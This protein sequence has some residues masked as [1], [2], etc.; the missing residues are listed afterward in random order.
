MAM[1]V[2][3]IEYCK[4]NVHYTVEGDAVK[5]KISDT[6][7]NLKKNKVRV[8][9][10]RPGKASDLAIRVHL[11]KHINE[12]VKE[13]LVAQ[14]YDDILFETKMKPI[15]YPQIMNSQLNGD[16]FLV[17]MLFLKKPEFE[18]KGYK[19]L[20]LPKPHMETTVE[21]MTQ[22]LLQ[23]L[24]EFHGDTMPYSETDFV[25]M[26]DQITMDV[27]VELDGKPVDSLAKE[28]V[29]YKVGER[30]FEG[31]DDSI[32][33]MTAGE[34]RK[35]EL[36]L[37]DK[38][39]LGMVID[40]ED[41]GVEDVKAAFIVNIHMGTKKTPCPLDDTLAEKAGFKNF[42]ELLQAATGRA[43]GRMQENERNMLSQQVINKLLENNQFEVPAWLTNME[44]QRLAQNNGVKLEEMGEEGSRYMVEQAEKQVRLSLILDSVRENEVEAV[45]SN[46]ELL[47]AMTNRL[48]QAGHTQE[49]A[50]TLLKQAE[51]QGSLY[52]MIAQLK[53]E[54]TLQWLIEHSKI[55][56]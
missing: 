20:E 33:G 15:G 46:N 47:S 56:E 27:K 18:L 31:F 3:E 51:R 44:A 42:E 43:S 10:Y 4:V 40:G 8:P 48:M 52:G 24:R 16:N 23:Q 36:V 2:N 32:L 41:P 17:D 21:N 13:E 54:T 9:G 29:L 12:K 7:R 53:D 25:Q 28:G 39:K 26:G 6:V 34:E 14:A 1:Q 22:H 30:M 35:F 19:D 49:S 11:K 50:N 45:F 38:T 37:G 55:V 5:D